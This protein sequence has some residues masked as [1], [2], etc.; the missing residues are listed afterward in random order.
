MKIANIIRIATLII[1]MA[2]AINCFSQSFPTGS[3]QGGTH[4]NIKVITW[5]GTIDDD[6]AEPSNWCPAVVPDAQDDVVI[7][8]SASV[9]PEV[10]TNGLSCKSLTLE[11]GA[12]LEIKTGNTLT[13]NGTEIE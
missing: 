1:L 13:V 7:P 9:M 11:P 10:K 3:Y 12:T 2:S 6:W 5:S 4:G 8:V